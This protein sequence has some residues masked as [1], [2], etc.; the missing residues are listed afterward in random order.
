MKKLF[1][2]LSAGTLISQIFTGSLAY[3]L[4]VSDNLAHCSISNIIDFGHKLALK[5]HLLLMGLLPVYIAIVIFGAALL[6][7]TLGRW[8]DDTLIPFFKQKS[9]KESFQAKLERQI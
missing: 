4:L 1:P 9:S 8:L 3:Y 7:A 5:Q 6:G 2:K